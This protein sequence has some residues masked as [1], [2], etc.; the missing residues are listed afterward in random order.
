MVKADIEREAAEMQPEAS[1]SAEATT[2]TP[3]ASSATNDDGPPAAPSTDGAPAAAAAAGVVPVAAPIA[4]ELPVAA[5]ATEK[6]PTQTP[7][8]DVA[9]AAMVA[10]G[11]N[12][13]AAPAASTEVAME[14]VQTASAG[15]VVAEEEP[16]LPGLMFRCSRYVRAVSS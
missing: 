2:E 6:P 15:D 9:S 4:A 7:A 11:S 10:S 1:Q 13:P 16:R 12:V 5:P 8:V 3:A 14:E